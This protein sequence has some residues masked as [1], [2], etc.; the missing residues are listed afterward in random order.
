MAD[1]LTTQ[2]AGFDKTRRDPL[3]HRQP[4]PQHRRLTAFDL[5][6]GKQN[7]LAENDQVPTSAACWRIRPRTP[8]RP[9]RST[10]SR[11]EWQILDP[12][13]KPDLEYLKTVADGEIE[14]TSR[15]LDDK[16]WIVAYLDRRRPGALLPLRS[17]RQE[18]HVPVHQP[19]GAAKAC[20][21]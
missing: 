4:R 15:T 1:T 2:P 5:K 16:L 10:T 20:R 8:S 9:W 7:V 6:T 14:V 13:I 19:H 11:K 17:R 12:A 3:L 18:G 21:W